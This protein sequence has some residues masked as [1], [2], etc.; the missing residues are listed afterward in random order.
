MVF[1]F[2]RRQIIEEERIRMLKEHVKNLVGYL[3]KGLLTANDLPHL[4]TDVV[5]RI[6]QNKNQC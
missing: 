2:F 1:I 3:P 5:D 4:G 6:V